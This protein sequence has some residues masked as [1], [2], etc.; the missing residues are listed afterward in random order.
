LKNLSLQ[1]AFDS[2]FHH[3]LDFNDFLH[4]DV[5][6]E[7]KSFEIDKRLILSPSNKLK[8][9]HKFLNNFVFDYAKINSDAVHAYRREK[10]PYTAVIKHA[11]SKYFFQTDIQDF[12]NSITLHDIEVVLDNNLSDALISD[13]INYKNQLLNLITVNG[14]LPIG[15]ST[16]PNISN[17]CLYAFDNELDSYCQREDIIYTRYSDD[18]ILSSNNKYAFNGIEKIIQDQ[19]TCFFNDRIRLNQQKTKHINKGTKIKL[20]GMVIL[21]SGN[22]SIDMRVK[23][24]LEILMHFYINDK[25]KFTDYLENKY[26]GDFT[27]ISGQINYINTIDKLYI[28]KLRKK[29]GNFVVDAF[30]NKTIK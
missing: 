13:I 11:H 2:T 19:L 6:K 24:Q 28:N 10:N 15:F 27:K 25:E 22:I 14:T 5:K 26:K 29:Y 21:P 18:I 16:S 30:H 23:E 4:L 7:C 1:E 3:K 12:F 20:L 17:T 9:F 8:K